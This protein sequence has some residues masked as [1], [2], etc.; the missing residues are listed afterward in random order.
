MH[1]P[2]KHAGSDSDQIYISSEVMTK[3][4]PMIPAHW[5]AYGPDPFWPKP[6]SVSQDQNGSGL[7]LHSRPG[8]S[9]E[10]WHHI[11]CWK[12]DPA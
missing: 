10:G 5:L 12:L 7:V 3:V 1:A 11:R 8:P 2:S 9:L 4:D 6:E